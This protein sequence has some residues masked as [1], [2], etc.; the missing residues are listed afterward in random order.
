MVI[1]VPSTVGIS[2]ATFIVGET[3]RALGLMVDLCGT[4]LLCFCGALILIPRPSPKA[5]TRTAT[6]AVVFAAEELGV[7]HGA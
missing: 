5:A 2:A 3:L 6:G 7:R 4:A 1:N